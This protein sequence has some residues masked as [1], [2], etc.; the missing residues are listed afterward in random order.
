MAPSKKIKVVP[1]AE[2][3]EGM[4]LPSDPK[5]VFLGGLFF[6]ALLA[7]AYVAREV[8]MPLTF[9]VVLALLLQPA[10][11]LLERLRLPRTLAAL[12]LIFALL[13][14]IV[15]LGTAVSGPARSWAGKLPEGIPRLQEKLSFVREPVNT[16]QR[17]LQ[18]VENF[19]GTESKNTA[20]SAQGPTFLTRLFTGTRNFASGFFT[21]VLFLFFLLVSGDI[22]LQRFVEILPRFSS[23][24][25]VVE[26]DQQI[27]RDISAY[28]VTITIMNAAVGIAVAMAMWLTGVGDPILWG[29]VAFLLN[30]VPILGPVLGVVI[31]LLAGLLTHD[32]LWQALLPAGLYLGI[33][34]IEGETVTPM[35]VAKRFT[36]NP[37]LVIISFVFW[38]WLWGVPGA[39][40]SFPML[41][42][43]KIVC[44][45]VKSLAVFGH[46]LE[47]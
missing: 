19:G 15:G 26:I 42:I 11:R 4:P 36:L 39:I 13:G 24:R 12:L 45:R 23:K 38:F 40:L 31:F 3:P 43:A 25:Q 18:Q 27:E 20:E 35:L 1:P 6:L 14:T 30:Y 41:A 29:T 44:D 2:E 33:H 17:F 16:L 9:A 22:F 28:L 5:A 10:L 8:I 32:V 47:G 34:L 46:F 21:T 7:A 37:V